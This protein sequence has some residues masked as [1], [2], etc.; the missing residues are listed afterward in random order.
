MGRFQY[1]TAFTRT[2]VTPILQHI[3]LDLTTINIQDLALLGF[4]E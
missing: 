4:I 1:L 2:V 3:A